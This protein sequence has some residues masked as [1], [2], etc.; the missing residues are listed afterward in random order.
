MRIFVVGVVVVIL[1][2]FFVLSAK[3]NTEERMNLNNVREMTGYQHT[4]HTNLGSQGNKTT[5]YVHSVLKST[6]KTHFSNYERSE[7]SLLFF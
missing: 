1:K 2:D 3:L 6:K 7:L 4:Q 5:K